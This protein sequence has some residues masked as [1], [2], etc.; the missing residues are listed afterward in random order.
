[1]NNNDSNNFHR[2]NASNG[3]NKINV[4]SSNNTPVINNK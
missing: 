3:F 4:D 1:M 2:F